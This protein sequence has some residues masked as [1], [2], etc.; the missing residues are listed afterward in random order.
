VERHSPS[1]VF[2]G[3]SLPRA[4]LPVHPCASFGR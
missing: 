3:A 1:E 4:P 2:T